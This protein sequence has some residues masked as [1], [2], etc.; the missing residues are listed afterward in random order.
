MSWSDVES[1]MPGK[2]DRFGTVDAS[3]A[4]AFQGAGSNL[5][6][7]GVTP[8]NGVEFSPSHDR[9]VRPRAFTD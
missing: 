6:W 8:A 9:S 7:E 4:L 3:K 1:F 2:A 5:V